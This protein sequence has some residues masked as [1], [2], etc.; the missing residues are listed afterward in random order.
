MLQESRAG[1]TQHQECSTVCLGMLVGIGLNR[2]CSSIW[3]GRAAAGVSCKQNA[4]ESQ[5]YGAAM[6]Q[7][8]MN[9]QL[10]DVFAAAFRM[11]A[12]AQTGVWLARSAVWVY[13]C[14]VC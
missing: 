12:G 4:E 1:R 5:Q 11:G 2:T 6:R 7:H 14:Y 3:T 8:V 10:V 13:V 9:L